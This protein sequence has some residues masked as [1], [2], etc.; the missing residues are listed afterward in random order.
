MNCSKQGRTSE[1]ISKFIHQTDGKYNKTRGSSFI[2]PS[3][4]EQIASKCLESVF[5]ISYVPYSVFNHHCY[6]DWVLHCMDLASA[7]SSI[8]TS[9]RQVDKY[10][11]LSVGTTMID[12]P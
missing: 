4:F 11:D 9:L 3:A 6:D 10:S 5:Y 8:V 12:I 2:S 1:N 7:E